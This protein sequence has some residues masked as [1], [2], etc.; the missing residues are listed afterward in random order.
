MS[1]HP[2]DHLAIWAADNYE[3]ASTRAWLDWIDRVEKLLGHDSDGDQSEDGYSL[4]GFLELYKRGLH[5]AEA[6]SVIGHLDAF[7]QHGYKAVPDHPISMR[8]EEK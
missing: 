4:D 6:I 3:S 5:P 1:E 7:L 8:G 2:S